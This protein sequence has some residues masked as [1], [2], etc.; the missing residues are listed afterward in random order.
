MARRPHGIQP[1][2]DQKECWGV[3]SKF[4]S[5]ALGHMR[6]Q[7]DSRTTTATS[8]SPKK[9]ERDAVEAAHR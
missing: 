8:G 3:N 2:L 9:L 1:R 7:D 6:R 5:Y 4:A